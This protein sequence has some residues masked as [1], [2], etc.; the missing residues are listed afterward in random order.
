LWN[1]EEYHVNSSIAPAMVHC[2]VPE[3]ISSP[4]PLDAGGKHFHFR[5]EFLK[6]FLQTRIMDFRALR[7]AAVLSKSV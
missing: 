1:G 5:D 2:R 3:E 7:A 4:A 6:L